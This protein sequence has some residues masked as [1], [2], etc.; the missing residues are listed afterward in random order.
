MPYEF[1]QTL[2]GLERAEDMFHRLSD[3][4]LR[5]YMVPGAVSWEDWSTIIDQYVHDLVASLRHD[6]PQ[7]EVADLFLLSDDY[8]NLKRAVQSRVGY[9][10]KTNLFTEARLA[11]VAG[12]NTSLLP[13]AIRPAIA[14][15]ML[16]SGGGA[17][18][19]V[20]TDIILDGAFLRHTLALARRLGVPMISEW[21][22]VRVLSRVLITLWRA[23]RAG[24]TLKLYP[25]HF[26][27]LGAL[28]GLVTDCCA[29]SDPRA[30]AAF[31]PGPMN[32]FW[33]DALEY[34]ENEQ[35][36]KFEQFSDNYLT[37]MA[38]RAKLQTAGPERVAGYLWGL[39]MESFNL[40]L[41]ISGKLN[42]LDADL[43]K[44][45]IR[46]TYV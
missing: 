18:N 9:P 38:R 17:D 34:P 16:A 12:G 28:N 36:T 24:H 30:W 8:L 33:R 21:F 45:R 40:K 42:K 37:G 5:E 7:T 35:V 22:E 44:T 39:W 3:T 19:P 25:L 1:F 27:P 29:I 2:A 23:V 15:L 26:L 31:I 6:S 41:V 4:S 13:D 46:E 10:F 43:L 20:L 11:E 14:Q 32:A